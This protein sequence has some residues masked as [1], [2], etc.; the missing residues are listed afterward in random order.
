MRPNP[1]KQDAK[2]PN[3]A[4]RTSPSMVDPGSQLGLLIPLALDELENKM[5]MYTKILLTIIAAALVVVAT[6]SAFKPQPALAFLDGPTLGEWLEA[7]RDPS[8]STDPR[9]IAM[10]APLVAVCDGLRCANWSGN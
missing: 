7:V 2:Q 3:P 8:D 1:D 6:N 5:D 9:E 4:T 10:R